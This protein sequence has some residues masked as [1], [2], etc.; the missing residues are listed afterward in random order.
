MQNK[1]YLPFCFVV[2]LLMLFCANTAIAQDGNKDMVL[3]GVEGQKT[4]AYI[5][6]KVADPHCDASKLKTTELEAFYIDKY[7]TTYADVLQCLESGKCSKQNGALEKIKN[8][9]AKNPQAANLPYN[10]SFNESVIEFDLAKQYCKA[11]GKRLPSPEE[12][13]LAAMGSQIQDYPWGA[14]KTDG[15]Y[16]REIS[17]VGSFPRDLSVWGAYDMGGNAAEYVEGQR[18]GKEISGVKCM[19]I[20]SY[21][22]MGNANRIKV[23][24]RFG[25]ADNQEYDNTF[26]VSSRC[27]K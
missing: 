16:A 20:Y 24:E 13:L 17:A 23:Y 7:E 5:P 4:K 11:Q 6:C 2:S 22:A 27:A 25:R 10:Y 12:W 3:V 26:Y 8:Y 18:M 9:L 21:P 19:S 15:I 14:D 1:L